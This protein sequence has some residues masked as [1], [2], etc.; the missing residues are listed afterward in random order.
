M[1]SKEAQ[2]ALIS[3]QRRASTTGE[4]YFQ[5]RAE[6]ALDEVIRNHPKGSPAAFQIRSAWA[7][8]GKAIA[9]R[10]AIV[11][12]DSLDH[13][14]ERYSFAQE[15]A[16]TDGGYALV[17]LLQWIHSTSAL[18]DRERRLMLALADGEDAESIASTSGVPI[19]RVRERISR[20]RKV[21]RA[22]Y[23]LE[24]AV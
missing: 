23:N 2:Q 14:A 15:P 20:V 18:T 22:A 3:L 11:P 4:V 7:N 12:V 9:H 6:R 16:I 5:E 8:A 13:E 21:A 1:I 10:H 17:D 24:V 19:K